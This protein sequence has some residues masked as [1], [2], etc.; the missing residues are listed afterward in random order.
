MTSS[1]TAREDRRD[2]VDT[3]RLHVFVPAIMGVGLLFWL[4][5]E[6][7][8]LARA[9]LDSSRD[10][11]ARI[12]G[13]AVA[14]GVVGG[15]IAD[16]PEQ[17]GLRSRP[18]Y[19]ILAVTLLGGAVYVCVGSVANYL[20]PG[21]YVGDIAWLLAVALAV[22]GVA[23]VLGV[24]AAAT[25]VRWPSPPRWTERWLRRSMLTTRPV[26]ASSH[27][28]RPS[29]RLGAAVLV[30][31]AIAGLSS[32]AVGGSPHLIEGFDERLSNWFDD[33]E[34]GWWGAAT[35]L[36]F[37][38]GG[39]VM[40]AIVVSVA[41]LRCRSLTTAYLGATALG[42]AAGTLVHA[43]VVRSRPPA[44]ARLGDDSF[45][46]G[47]AVQS[48][49]M[50]VLL[51]L[52][53]AT[54]TNRRRVHVPFQ[55]VLAVLAIGDAVDRVSSGE[56]WPTDVIGG[57]AL[58]LTL[59]LGGKWIVEDQ[60]AHT[61]CRGCP[62]A[63]DADRAG[64]RAGPDARPHHLHHGHPAHP[65]RY[66]HPHVPLGLIELSRS[67]G[68]LVGLLAR[69]ASFLAVTGLVIA[70]VVVGLPQNGE[71]YVFGAEIERP[72]QLALAGLL[73]IGALVAR[74]LPGTGAVVMAVAAACLGVFAA[75]QYPP[76]YATVLTAL[77]MVPAFLTWL[78]WQHR[79]T[80]HE[81]TA[82]AVT[83]AL[84]VGAT[85]TGARS[86]YD[87]YFGP[88]HPES[89][90]PGLPVDEVRWVLAGAISPDSVTVTAR[91][92]DPEAT[93]VLRVTSGP[94]DPGSLSDPA[95]TDEYGVVRMHVEG[96]AANTRYSYRVV[97]DGE[98]DGGRGFGEFRT[99]A[100][101]PMSF[102][103][104]LGACART[105]SNGSVFD[106]MA[107][108]DALMYLVLGDIH[109]GNIDATEPGPFL[110]ALDRVLTRP[111][112]AALYRSTAFAY[113]WDD[114]DYGPNDADSSSPGRA[115]VADVY[116][117]VV[118]SAPLV[119]DV[120][121]F[122][123]FTVGRVRFVLTDTRSQRTDDATLGDEQLA[124]LLDELVTASRTHALVVWANG[125]PW[126]GAPR[127]GGDGW[128]GYASERALISQTIADAGIDNLV[129]VSG[130]A[131]MVAI[132]DGTNTGYAATPG[133][134]SF[135]LLQAAALD[136]HG[137]VKGGPYSEGAFP[138]GGQYGVLD[139]DDPG[140]D[141]PVTV[142]LSGRTWDGRTLVTDTFEFPPSDAG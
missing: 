34:L 111:A 140:G 131:H 95:T 85:W 49:V 65:A 27:L 18:V 55:L 79:R 124:W 119:D 97:V 44:G 102:T 83:T 68:S 133:S 108:E 57:A 98:P 121:I 71:G 104:V 5:G 92:Q 82:V 139:V 10:K 138:G 70:T 63:I 50:A 39:V 88:T 62:W 123:S 53:V 103:V 117:S 109:Y 29:W 136:R 76:A 78:G 84:L 25:F 20:R 42:M 132:D 130:D 115:A 87:S 43:V 22:C 122:Q 72:A 116:R 30:A 45:P 118:P 6:L 100:D 73:S 128:P 16:R 114:H 28:A 15:D 106:A 19:A 126:I 90:T 51:P 9:S 101:G 3:D 4:V 24:V 54:L 75:I 21:G 137:N 8:D 99:A 112:Q 12:A 77:L 56:H 127:P 67:A 93:A 80:P 7:R 2:L 59:G 14:H 46:S 40:I 86:V 13:H 32:L 66:D 64:N 37:G 47:H 141:A 41:A 36:V 129:M 89:A 113:I 120:A 1:L 142:T 110:D 11:Q 60:R 74:R 107:A 23:L 125:V 91:L 81:L 26:D 61:R 35:D 69:A 58:G 94:D 33:V 135:P 48:M 52:A 105:G 96:L 134:G 17:R 31:A 38:T